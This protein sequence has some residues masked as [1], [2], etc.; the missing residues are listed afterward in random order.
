MNKIKTCCVTGHRP[1]GF[2]WNY[3]D[4]NCEEHKKYLKTIFDK[5][6]NL[7][8]NEKCENFISGGALGVDM[9]FAEIVI[10]LRDHLY[11]QI[12]LEIAVPCAEQDIRWKFADKV[13]YNSI[14]ESADKITILSKNYTRFC[15]QKRN[16][17]MVDKAD[18]VLAIWNGKENG[19]TYNTIAYAK[20]QN[21]P[22]DIIQIE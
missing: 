9:D 2:L 16:E 15:M 17:Y 22:I 5:I 20:S 21:K 14:C 13:R 19:G 10:V 8:E 12:K 11:P 6:R 7:V 4:K 18:L 1:N 3:N